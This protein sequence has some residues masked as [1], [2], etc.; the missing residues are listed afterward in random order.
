LYVSGGNPAPD[1]A[2]GP[3]EGENQDSRSIVVLTLR[4]GH[5]L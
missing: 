4:P 1:F 2:I 3:R 5:T